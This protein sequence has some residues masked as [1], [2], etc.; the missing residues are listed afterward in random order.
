MIVLADMRAAP[1][2]GK[3]PLVAARTLWLE[4][5]PLLSEESHRREHDGS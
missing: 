1:T 5:H 2:A 4:T 3:D